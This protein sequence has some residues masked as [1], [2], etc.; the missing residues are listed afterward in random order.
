[1]YSATAPNESAH[2]YRV[3]RRSDGMTQFD[4]D[5]GKLIVGF[6]PLEADR[7]VFVAWEQAERD[8]K[9]ADDNQ[10]YALLVAQT[11]GAFLVYAPSCKDDQEAV[12]RD[13]GATVA[14]GIFA[15]CRFPSRARLE[16]ALR[17]LSRDDN[18]AMRLVRIRS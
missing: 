14:S 16:Q 10:T 18:S 13:S 3:S 15:T 8:S 1:V 5:D 11:D 9:E 12:A 4:G 2:L 7:G 17:R 6:A